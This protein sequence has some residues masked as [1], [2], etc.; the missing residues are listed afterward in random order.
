M[1]RYAKPAFNEQTPPA[2]RS[3]VF[4][5]TL[6]RVLNERQKKIHALYRKS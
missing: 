1:L 2:G 6:R 4:P 3:A 5:E